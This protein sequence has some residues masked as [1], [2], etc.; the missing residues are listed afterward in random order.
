MAL[1]AKVKASE[2]PTGSL[3]TMQDVFDDVETEDIKTKTN[4]ISEDICALVVEVL[5]ST[6]NFSCAPSN[7][8]R[9]ESRLGL[10]VTNGIPSI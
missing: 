10:G 4:F 8:T 5:T 3:T 6:S 2:L 9:S 7:I 1:L